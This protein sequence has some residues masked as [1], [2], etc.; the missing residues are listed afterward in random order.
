M[1]LYIEL[2]KKRKKITQITLGEKGR[3]LLEIV[4]LIFFWF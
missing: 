3:V 1:G 4:R 2:N